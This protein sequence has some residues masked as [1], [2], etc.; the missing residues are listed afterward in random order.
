MC[1]CEVG[2][3]NSEE[4]LSQ[5]K[6]VCLLGSSFYIMY[7]LLR[8][9]SRLLSMHR[10]FQSLLQ[11]CGMTLPKKVGKTESYAGY[12]FKKPKKR[13]QYVNLGISCH[14]DKVND[15]DVVFNSIWVL[16]VAGCLFSILL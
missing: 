7:H 16:V 13:A 2:P 11:Q 15:T 3:H 1:V 5:Y 12:S 4:C 9:F 6:L 10:Y 14:A 8:W